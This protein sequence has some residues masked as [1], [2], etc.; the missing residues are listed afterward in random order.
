MVLR[1]ATSRD[2]RHQVID[3]LASDDSAEV[4]SRLSERAGSGQEHVIL[5][6][7]EG[8]AAAFQR[9]RGAPAV[10]EIQ[11]RSMIDEPEPSVPAEQVGVAR[12]AVDVG[13]E[14]VE[15]H[16]ARGRDGVRQGAHDRIEGDAPRQVI[17]AEVQPGAGL[18]RGEDLGI[19]LALGELAIELDKDDLG[20]EE[21]R[22]AGELPRQQLGDQHLGPLARA[23]ELDDI[24]PEI[25]GL[26]EG[27]HGAALA[28]GQD[29]T[30]GT[31]RAQPAARSLP[32]PT[33]LEKKI[34]H[35]SAKAADRAL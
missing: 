6:L 22:G 8:I 1:G 2:L 26:H 15:E 7:G 33:R 12:R 31:D 5:H 20:Q 16:D 25:V 3:E 11:R 13:D 10:V 34:A 23:A 28:E 30:D 17:E 18:E 29:I 24:E 4:R 27:R 32:G 19:Q 21:P 35:R 14:G 9:V